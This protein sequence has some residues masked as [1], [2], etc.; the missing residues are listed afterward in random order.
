MLAR[1]A[2]AGDLSEIDV[3]GSGRYYLH[4]LCRYFEY[5]SF[6]K[7]S[8]DFDSM[9]EFESCVEAVRPAARCKGVLAFLSYLI[10]RE[11]TFL[12]HIPLEHRP[13]YLNDFSYD[14]K[15]VF[16]MKRIVTSAADYVK[17]RFYN[18]SYYSTFEHGIGKLLVEMDLFADK[19]TGG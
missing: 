16:F 10:D 2:D 17:R 1:D 19:W 7:D 6:M 14:S 5:V 8:V 11:E 15:A 4:K 18:S 3:T 13:R 12:K 9:P